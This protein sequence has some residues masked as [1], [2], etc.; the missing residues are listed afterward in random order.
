[1]ITIGRPKDISNINSYGDFDIAHLVIYF[2]SLTDLEISTLP[3]I[4][5]SK[6]TEYDLICCAKKQSRYFS[7]YI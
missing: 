2:R 3:T 7:I 4:A 6:G 1:M 5:I